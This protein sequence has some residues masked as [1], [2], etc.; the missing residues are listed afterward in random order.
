MNES[1]K[2]MARFMSSKLRLMKL[3]LT[4]FQSSHIDLKSF[5]PRAT[6]LSINVPKST[7]VEN[8]YVIH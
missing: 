2:I 8:Y 4:F 6:P 7:R 3:P 5:I 1:R